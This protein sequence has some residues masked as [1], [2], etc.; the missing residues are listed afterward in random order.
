MEL[1]AQSKK[2][3]GLTKRGALRAKALTALL[4]RAGV[5]G[6]TVNVIWGFGSRYMDGVESAIR[7][8]GGSISEEPSRM[9]LVSKDSLVSENSPEIGE[10]LLR[11]LMNISVVQDLVV[12]VDVNYGPQHWTVPAVAA[13]AR[14]NGFRSVQS[15]N[16]GL[17]SEQIVLLRR[18]VP[19]P[20]DT[21]SPSGQQSS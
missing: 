16:L 10:V 15:V 6:R 11:D 2:R 12:F 17:R 19:S 5:R 21:R 8:L 14:K 9:I 1:Q 3:P 4:Q 7:G 18:N 13:L 20:S